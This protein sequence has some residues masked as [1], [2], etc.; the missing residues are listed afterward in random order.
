MF[1]ASPPDIQRLIIHLIQPIAASLLVIGWLT[2]QKHQTIAIL[3]I[4]MVVGILIY[5]YY[6]VRAERIKASKIRNAS[7]FGM[8]HSHALGMRKQTVNNKGNDVEVANG[9]KIMAPTSLIMRKQASTRGL[10][11]Q[12]S[13]KGENLSSDT[14][15]S[16]TT[17]FPAFGT[18][19]SPRKASSI[20]P[21]ATF[22]EAS[23][24]DDEIRSVSTTNALQS[25][26]SSMVNNV[27]AS[28]CSESDVEKV[29]PNTIARNDNWSTNKV[30][31]NKVTIKSALIES[32]SDDE[33]KGEEEDEE[34]DSDEDN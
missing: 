24:K 8:T 3:L 27:S 30:N 19:S 18:S 32:E 17:Q 7:N 26:Q 29:Y 2:A 14:A 28:D 31:T 12:M 6:Q 10:A 34:E 11:S 4:I 23:R 1:G 25:T 21:L 13:M 9:D 20:T 15:S 16:S 5:V 33:E 22:N